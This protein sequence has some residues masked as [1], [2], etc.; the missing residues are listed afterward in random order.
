[1]KKSVILVI[2]FV[3]VVFI[4]V[5]ATFLLKKIS[6]GTLCIGKFNKAESIYK[7]A[8]ESFESGDNDKGMN[9]LFEIINQYPDSACTEKSLRR[10]AEVFEKKEEY[11]KTK[12]YYERILRD[13]PESEQAPEIC[14]Y[15]EKLNMQEMMSPVITAD[16]VEYEIQ[17][18]DSL[19][20]IAKSFNTSVSLIKRINELK[21]DLIHPGQKLKIIVSKFSILVDKSDN[22]LYLKKDGTVFKTYKVSTGKDNSTPAGIFKIEEKMVKPL[23][24]KVGAI[25]SSD[26]EQYELGER[27]MGLSVKGYG[28][29][30][31]SDETTIGSQITQGCVRMCNNDVIE[32][33]DIV[34]SGTEV[35]IAD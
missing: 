7:K 1:M 34:P 26:S 8:E 27:W 30:G 31:T 29:H 10:L 9:M 11:D 12:Y 14:G 4:C 24:Y 23:W 3:V 22:I 19:Y 28:I 13:F 35:E 15:V 5:G 25:V 6:G 32:L 18:G 16:S 21:S 20:G 33:F 17:A 2:S